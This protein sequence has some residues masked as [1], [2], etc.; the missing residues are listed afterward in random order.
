MP[1]LTAIDLFCG[2]GG[3][4]EEFLR[5]GW[6]V[7]GYDIKRWRK[8]GPHAAYP[9]ELIIADVC[10]LTAA[11]IPATSPA[12]VLAS[13]PCTEFAK[14]DRAG[15]HYNLPAHPDM[16]CVEASYRIARELGAPLI[17]ENVR[18]LQRFHGPAVGHY[19]SFYLWGDVPAIL[20][21]CPRWTAL[22][23][24]RSS[25]LR[26]K[27]PA[28]LAGWLAE[29]FKMKYAGA[30]TASDPEPSNPSGLPGQM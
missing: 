14:H 10:R 29:Y 20:P 13:P 11:Q 17:L 3:W 9:G 23:S 25:A 19:G 21:H 16:A 2:R 6:R 26:A 8:W 5:H 28:P 24:A 18:G 4:A 27:I 30:S 15:L 7:I 12:V 22:K 1:Q